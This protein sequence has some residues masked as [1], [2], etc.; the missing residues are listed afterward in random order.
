MGA[1]SRRQ[2]EL[3]SENTRMAN[4]GRK[5]RSQL[6]ALERVGSTLSGCAKDLGG[7]AG[8]TGVKGQRTTTAV[9]EDA[10]GRA[11][12]R[13]ARRFDAYLEQFR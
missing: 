6:V 4:E 3:A 13:R 12:R 10:R 5:L 7:A 8:S 2:R 1:L 9:A 11:V